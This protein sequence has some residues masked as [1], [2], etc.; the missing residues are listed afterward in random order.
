MLN[1]EA[2]IFQNGREVFKM[3][4][5]GYEPRSSDVSDDGFPQK[6]QT[7]TKEIVATIINPFLEEI[8]KSY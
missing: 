7:C 5:P 4:I 3:Y 6:S 1:K 2:K 8:A